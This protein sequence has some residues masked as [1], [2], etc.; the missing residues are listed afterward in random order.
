[1][2]TCLTISDQVFSLSTC[3]TNSA[4]FYRAQ[5]FLRDDQM[6]EQVNVQLLKEIECISKTSR[7]TISQKWSQQNLKWLEH[8][9]QWKTQKLGHPCSSN[10]ETKK[11]EV[12][13]RKGPRADKKA[14]RLTKKSKVMTQDVDRWIKVAVDEYGSSHAEGSQT[15]CT[16]NVPTYRQKRDEGTTLVEKFSTGLIA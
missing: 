10:Q 6:I 15:P 4:S 14:Q 7:V 2:A 11:H 8:Q 1:M 5:S 9:A 16:R 13:K 12:V 3:Y